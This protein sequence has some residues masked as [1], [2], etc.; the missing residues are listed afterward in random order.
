MSARK[1]VVEDILLLVFFFLLTYSA[2]YLVLQGIPEIVEFI[3]KSFRGSLYLVLPFILFPLGLLFGGIGI[4]L[5]STTAYRLKGKVLGFLF[6]L[7]GALILLYSFTIIIVVFWR[8]LEN[9]IKR[10]LPLYSSSMLYLVK[11]L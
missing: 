7:I 1:G 3:N 5:A 9:I 10:V 4:R 6:L 11:L 2:A 8:E